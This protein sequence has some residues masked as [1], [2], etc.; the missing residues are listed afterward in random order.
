MLVF[1]LIVSSIDLAAFRSVKAEESKKEET[2]DT[3]ENKERENLIEIPTLRTETA[4]VFAHPDGSMSSEVM[5][6]PVHYKDGNEWKEI[7]NTLI[8]SSKT[9]EVENKE[10]EF[11]VR[12]P[13][14]PS[15]EGYS[16]LFSYHLNGKDVSFGINNKSDANSKQYSD[17]QETTL[18]SNEN[19]ATFK[20]LF[21]DVTFEYIVDGSKVKENIILDSYQGK[22]AFEFFIKGS[23]M[24]AK[25]RNDGVIE[26][27]DTETGK[28]LFIIQK[29][30]MFDSSGEKETE[31]DLSHR[32]TQN[33][34]AVTGGFLLTVTADE[35]YLKDPERVY[36]VIIDP[37][38]DVFDAKDTYVSEKAPTSNFS[39]ESFLYVG[40]DTVK[41]KTRS[42]LKWDLPTIPNA[43]VT[44]GEIGLR[45]NDSLSSETVNVHKLTAGYTPTT[46]NWN[47]QPAFDATPVQSRGG[48]QWSGY[49]YFPIDSLVKEWVSSP[50]KN[51]GVVL[52]FPNDKEGTSGRKTFYS[53]ENTAHS[54]T[55]PTKPKLVVYYRPHEMLGITDYW[56]YTP[57]LFQGEGTAVVNVINGNMIYD[58]GLLSLS[59]KTDAFNL[60]LVYNSRSLYQEAYGYGWTF[61]A[62][63]RLVPS[64]D[65]KIIE[66]IDEEGTRL[67]FGKQQY[68]TDTSYTAPE[69]VF[70]ELNSTSNGGYTIKQTDETVLTFDSLGRNTKVV[71][72]KGNTVLYAFDGT[73]KRITKISERYGSE[74]TGRDLTLSYQ[75]TT[76]L[77]EKVTDFRGTETFL[78]YQAL[79][80]TNRLA[81]ITYAANRTEKKKI[82]FGY[83]GTHQLVSVQDA[84]G[85][86][87]KIAYDASNRVQKIVDPRSDSMFAELSYPS[88][89]ETIFTDA[90]GNKTRYKNSGIDKP[91]VNI[92]E[93]TEDFSGAN[94]ATTLY[95]WN[96]NNLIK[97]TE[98]NPATGVPDPAVV[99]TASYDAKGNLTSSQ[100]P[101]QLTTENTFDNKS[102]VTKEVENGTSYEHVYDAKSNL[103]STSDHYRVVDYNAYD[104]YGNDI[105]SVSGTRITHN[106]LQNSNFERATSTGEAETWSRRS[107]GTYQLDGTSAKH[108]KKSAKVTLSGTDGAGYYTQ[109]VP[110]QSDEPSKYYTVAANIKTSGLTG[111]G[112]QIRVYPLNASKQTMTDETGKTIIFTTAALKGT[113]D[114]TRLSDFFQLPKDTAHIRYDLVAT[115]TGMVQFDSAQLL[116]GATLDNYYSNEYGSMEWEY[117]KSTDYSKLFALGTGDG[118]TSELRKR[119]DQS[120]ILNGV[121]TANRYFGQYVDV[122]GK[123]GDPITLSGWSYASGNNT[124]GDYRLRVWFMYT[125]GTEK[126]FD[127]PFDREIQDQ[128]QFVKQTFRAEKAFN[129][130]KVYGVFSKQNGVAFFENI[131]V[132]ENGSTTTEIYSEDGNFK[133]KSVDALGNVELS[134]YDK[135]GNNTSTT[136]ENGL[137]TLYTYDYL[138]RLKATTLVKGSDTDPENISVSYEHDDQGNIKTRTEP[139]G[140]KTT[141]EYNAINQVTKETDPVGKFL[142]N[143]YDV[144]GNVTV[145]ER[146]SGTTVITREEFSYDKKNRMTE[147]RVGG[148]TYTYEYDKADNQTAIKGSSGTYTFTYDDNKRLTKS[149]NPDGYTITNEYESN[150]NSPNLGER[151]NLTETFN[152]QSESTAYEYDI[153]KRLTKLTGPNGRTTSYYYDE[154]NQP[155]RMVNGSLSVFYHYNEAGQLIRQS[156]IGN[157]PLAIDH[158]YNPD[159]DINETT[160]NG[161]KESYTYDFAGRLASWTSNAKTTTYSYDKSGNLLNP[162]GMTLSFNGANEIEGFTYDAAGN[163]K[164]DNKYTYEWDQEGNLTAVKNL[165]GTVISSYTYQPGGL[166]KTKTVGSETFHYHYDGTDLVR[167]SD[168][169]KKTLWSFTWASGKPVSLTNRNGTTYY[170]V[171]NYHGDVLQIVDSNGTEV[172]NYRYDPWGNILSITENSELMNQ[173][174]GYAGYYMDKE[175]KLYYLQARYYDS[176][177]AR[178]ISK[179]PDPGDDDDPITQNGYTYADNSPVML[180]D[181]DGHFAQVIIPVAIGGYRLYKGYK[182]YKKIKNMKTIYK[183]TGTYINYHGKSRAYVGKGSIQRSRG[184]AK[185]KYDMYG[186]KATVTAWR[187]ANS[188]RQAFIREYKLMRKVGKNKRLY[189]RINSPGRKY[190]HQRYGRYYR[191]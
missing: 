5:L 135:N 146:G 136:D 71:D 65:K 13:E 19:Q 159:G 97:E 21:K 172:A 124:T 56:T 175:T 64:P 122:Q 86:T 1:V 110:V 131:K 98:P 174:L 25:K 80:G 57:D 54:K 137:K 188:H 6:E 108:G 18:V 48:T 107:I 79:N 55:F 49:N 114:W 165:N 43:I 143:D 52:K 100:S 155:V 36:P 163:L 157:K 156:S 180:I 77:L 3:T 45:Q 68:D 82:T 93:Q 177:T 161:Q 109:T 142:R 96:K 111:T 179:D 187:P 91:T 22:N 39:N 28:F 73:S 10:N 104:K 116:Y 16:Q 51:Y 42:L 128:W 26:F 183:K 167:V 9:N 17:V 11:T 181:P 7:D 186:K 118:L 53:Q 85:N 87:G 182:T 30:Y 75:P 139:R 129:R 58:I 63:K 191:E 106:R 160:I 173:P 38:I 185:Q 170:Y 72:E 147:K 20:E 70:L 2:T 90:N 126:E 27:T 67:H 74:T 41:G 23:G 24:D 189:N 8:P 102:N 105:M 178:F 140:N 153:L 141:F 144:T 162:N 176:E 190:Y 120:F 101:N 152:G 113:N 81:S 148:K 127:L 61:N 40:N 46:V 94:Q 29:P 117:D 151:K 84:N 158:V 99:N 112:A 149:V 76:G 4:K 168:N 171:T 60:K 62:G 169:N 12:F 145:S 150:T 164:R 138:D 47:N 34:E 78:A 50:S 133:E 123:A 103:I 37:W 166:R 44:G 134:T 115:G 121:S 92:I 59:G 132:E 184:S 130:L 95:E 35:A 33:I 125:D 83:S 119:G 69:G 66:Y 154:S 32:V 89:T 88:G 31:S 15:D 14:K